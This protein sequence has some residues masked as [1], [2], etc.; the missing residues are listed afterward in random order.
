MRRLRVR[1]NA[2]TPA[3]AAKARAF[4]AEGIGLCR[5]EHMFFGPDRLLAVREMILADSAEARR[6][7]L[8]KILPI[9]R[10]DFVGIFRAMDGYPVT[11]RLL[12]PPLHEFLPQTTAEQAAVAAD[13]GISREAVYR[14][15][16]AL[17]EFNPMLGHRGVRLAI[18]YPEIY[19]VQTR[20]ILEA[21]C[22]VARDGVVVIP[23]IMAPLVAMASELAT[24][25]VRLVPGGGAGLR[26]A[27]HAAGLH[28]RHDDSS[29]RA[30]ASP[31]TRSPSTPTSSRSAPTT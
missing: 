21:A 7:A 19:E 25:R 3:D 26:R 23:E 13:L 12:D 1:T 15:V 16:E 6:A 4:G 10:E 31:R 5:T 18:T 8:A 28:D 9:Q 22:A 24:T 29:C 30:P 27:G 11:V 17:A 14:R 2:D 20:A